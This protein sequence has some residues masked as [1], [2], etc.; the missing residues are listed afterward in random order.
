MTEENTNVFSRRRL[1]HVDIKGAGYFITFCLKKNVT[2][3]LNEIERKIVKEAIL[4][5]HNKKWIVYEI[6]VMPD[7]THILVS[8][9]S[10]NENSLESICRILKSVK[11][12]SAR[13]INQLRNATGSL[14]MQESY[15]R[16]IR[17]E[18]QLN[19]YL[20]YIF[21]N[22]VRAGLVEDGF[23]YDGFWWIGKELE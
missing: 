21:N 1:P 9:Q 10:E 2:P 8:T 6:S 12:F 5:W 7:H 3:H 4:F 14:W 11:S 15:D 18:R 20:E 17:S 22:A 16:I 19:A 23:R 13:K